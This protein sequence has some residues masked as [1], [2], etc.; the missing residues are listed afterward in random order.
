MNEQEKPVLNCDPINA[1]KVT[2]DAFFSTYGFGSSLAGLGEGPI[3]KA[4]GLAH[5]FFRA[6][7]KG[8]EVIIK[9]DSK[10]LQ[11]VVAFHEKARKRG[12]GLG[13]EH[14]NCDKLDTLGAKVSEAIR[15]A[16]EP[17]GVIRVADP[18]KLLAMFEAERRVGYLTSGEKPKKKSKHLAGKDGAPIAIVREGEAHGPFRPS[19]GLTIEMLA[20]IDSTQLREH[21]DTRDGWWVELHL[22]ELLGD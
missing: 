3:V 10:S 8:E 9:S 13:L 5:Q 21:R 12:E 7:V 20:S 11:D 19:S 14:V 1:G 17:L 4:H 6:L 16:V 15:E 18:Q 22:E 2:V